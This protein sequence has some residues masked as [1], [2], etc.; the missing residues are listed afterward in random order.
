MQRWLSYPQDDIV[1]LAADR[2]AAASKA[3][4]VAALTVRTVAA[5]RVGFVWGVSG[6]ETESY[7]QY[8]TASSRV[9]STLLSMFRSPLVRGFSVLTLSVPSGTEMSACIPKFSL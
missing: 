2:C 1:I 3:A 4:A 6:G 8:E 7:M 5:L 9:S